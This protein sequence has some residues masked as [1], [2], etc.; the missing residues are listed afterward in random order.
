MVAE[1]GEQLTQQSGATFLLAATLRL[2]RSIASKGDMADDDPSYRIA[3][4][5]PMV[6]G[7]HVL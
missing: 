7:F 5:F 1:A 6:M 3:E 4:N 2:L